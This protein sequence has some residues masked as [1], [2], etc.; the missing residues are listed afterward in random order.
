MLELKNVSQKFNTKDVL[1]NISLGLHTGEVVTL[2]GPSGGGKTS[3]LKICCL[4][5][6]PITGDIVIDDQVCV[7]NGKLLVDP[8]SI[9]PKVTIIFQELYL[10]PHLTAYENIILPHQN[11]KQKMK[12]IHDLVRLFDLTPHM[13][14]YPNELSSGQKQRVAIMRALLLE[15][16][17]ILMDEITASLDVEQTFN[18]LEIITKLKSENVGIILITHHLEFAKKIS[19]QIIFLGNGQ[20]IEKGGTEMISTPKN[21][22]VIDFVNKLKTIK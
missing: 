1:Q 21:A 14:K 18:I 3:L 8:N 10:W 4:L 17:Y 20:V 12:R 16:K 9:W 2:I 6:T 13:N 15:P 5:N 19:D 7:Q 22:R 11:F